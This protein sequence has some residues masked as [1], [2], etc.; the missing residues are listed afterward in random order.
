MGYT[1]EQLQKMG[2]TPVATEKRSYTLDDLRKM[3]AKKVVQ[4]VSPPAEEKGALQTLDEMGTAF[5]RKAG[6]VATFGLSEKLIQKGRELVHGEDE[7]GYKRQKAAVEAENPGSTMAGAVAGNL[8]PQGIAAKVLR[9]AKGVKGVMGVNA[10]GAAMREG[11]HVDDRDLDD[12]VE[13]VALSSL[14]EGGLGALGYGAGKLVS[15]VGTKA[16][17]ALTGLY[18]DVVGRAR[19]QYAQMGRDAMGGVRNMQLQNAAADKTLIRNAPGGAQLASLGSKVD[20]YLDRGAD[21]A[22]KYIKKFEGA[23]PNVMARKALAEHGKAA[24]KKIGDAAFNLGT[25][26]VLSSAGPAGALIGSI[27]IYRAA[28][29]MHRAIMQ[30]P[31]ML[32]RLVAL[33]PAGQ[34]L[35]RAF[36]HGASAFGAA[37]T[38][39]RAKDPAAAEQA[40]QI[41]QSPD[42]LEAMPPL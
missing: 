15:R 22:L 27:G 29:Q 9:G 19:A 39:L 41:L 10:L 13:D 4:P 38:V 3:G 35:G 20:D 24:T 23:D 21:N 17:G 31:A 6:D 42:Q 1:L 32:K 33:G 26:G 25:A 40:V 28:G 37:L 8:V 18:R 7:A 12:R 2:A 14:A 34:F 36:Q 11:L 30:H 16:K 5:A